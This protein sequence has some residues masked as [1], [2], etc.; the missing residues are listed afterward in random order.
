MLLPSVTTRVMRVPGIGK[1][2]FLEVLSAIDLSLL[3]TVSYSNGGGGF[4]T[5]GS[6]SCGIGEGTTGLGSIDK[7]DLAQ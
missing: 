3:G 1:V 7:P 5:L 2:V 6:D 4:G